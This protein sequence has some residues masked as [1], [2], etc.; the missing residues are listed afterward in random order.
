MNDDKFL[1]AIAVIAV[2]V[3]VVAAGFTYFSI[4]NLAARYTGFATG[5][6]NLTVEDVIDINFTTNAIDWGSGR[7]DSGSTSA[8]LDTLEGTTVNSNWTAN[9]AGL[10]IENIGNVNATLNISGT[11][12]AAAMIAGTSPV[13]QWNISNNEANSCVNQST[14][15]HA[16]GQN[17]TE[18]LGKYLN[19]NTTTAQFCP[20][21]AFRDAGDSVR[22]H[23]NLTIPSDSLTGTI[24][25]VITATAWP[26]P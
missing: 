12:T 10:L 25:D 8:Y 3:S 11:K 6:A 4:A 21:L 7:V 18:S 22:I 23:F 24:T 16:D 19:V 15:I 14:G 2:L 13:Y 1:L 9:S 20:I 5:E 17:G 26:Y